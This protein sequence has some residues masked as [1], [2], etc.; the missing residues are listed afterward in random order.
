MGCKTCPFC[1]E[2]VTD[3]FDGKFVK[4]NCKSEFIRGKTPIETWNNLYRKEEHLDDKCAG[5]NWK[6]LADHRY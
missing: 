6:G 4:H 1:L 2:D 5:S 3:V